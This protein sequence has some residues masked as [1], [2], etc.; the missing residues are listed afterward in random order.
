MKRPVI[1]RD[2]TWNTGDHQWPTNVSRFDDCVAPADSGEIERRVHYYTWVGVHWCDR[3]LVSALGAGLSEVIVKVYRSVA[4]DFEPDDE[5]YFVDFSRRSYTGYRDRQLADVTPR[6]LAGGAGRAGLAFRPSTTSKPNPQTTPLGAVCD[7]NNDSMTQAYWPAHPA[8]Q[9]DRHGR[10]RR[11]G[12]RLE[13]GGPE[14]DDECR[15]QPANCEPNW[16][17]PSPSRTS[18]RS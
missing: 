14:S 16:I 3:P 12:G 7:P 10:G 6:C 9:V 5:L 15:Y 11:R 1:C 2:G 13:R 17:A 4:A 18:C 8:D